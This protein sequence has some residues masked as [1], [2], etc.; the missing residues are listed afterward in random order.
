APG[1]PQDPANT[2]QGKLADA[3]KAVRKLEGSG[4]SD[5]ELAA[6]HTTLDDAQQQAASLPGRIDQAAAEW[7]AT[8]TDTSAQDRMIELKVELAA[9]TA[10]FQVAGNLSRF[11]LAGT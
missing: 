2:P 11:L 10:L 1:A 9:R 7:A 8:P 3:Q 5:A 6:A 4:A